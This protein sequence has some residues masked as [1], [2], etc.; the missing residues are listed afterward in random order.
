MIIDLILDRENGLPYSPDKFYNEVK[1][2]EG[3]FGEI[4]TDI[5]TAM[6]RSEY[7]TKRALCNYII[8]QG[9]ALN[10]LRFILAVEWL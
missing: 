1:S 2:Y 5:T 3:V 7:D 4:S 10:I 6:K 8:T 9:Y